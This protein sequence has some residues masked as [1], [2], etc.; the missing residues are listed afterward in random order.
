MKYSKLTEP[1]FIRRQQQINTRNGGHQIWEITFTGLQSR[2]DYT[3]WVDPNY[4]N[5][6]SWAHIIEIAQRRAVVL[7][8]LKFKD[9]KQNLINADSEPCVLYVVSHTELADTLNE[10]WN[11]Q[12]RFSVLFE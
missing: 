2:Q 5:Y 3:T 12:S 7:N 8:N 1:V 10:F 11:N 6:S 9:P 4:A